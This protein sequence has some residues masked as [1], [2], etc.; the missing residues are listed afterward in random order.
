MV[1]PLLL[2]TDGLNVPKPAM[3]PAF[4]KV[5]PITVPPNTLARHRCATAC[6]TSSV[7]ALATLPLPFCT[8]AFTRWSVPLVGDDGAKVDQLVG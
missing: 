3:L 5:E 6:A 2:T 4:V 1:A 8:G 7:P